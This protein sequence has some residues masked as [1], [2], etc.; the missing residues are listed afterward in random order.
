[1]KFHRRQPDIVFHFGTDVVLLLAC[2]IL[3]GLFTLQYFGTHRVAFLFAPV[4]LV[5]LLCIA[6]VGFYNILHW[7]PSILRALSPY[8]L[9][10]FFKVAGKEGWVSLGG[11]VLCITGIFKIMKVS[12]QFS[13]PFTRISVVIKAGFGLFWQGLRPCLLIWDISL[14]SQFGYAIP[15][16]IH[17][18]V[19][20][21]KSEYHFILCCCR[22]RLC[23]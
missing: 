6:A 15:L 20:H 1:M 14:N 2:I 9:Y 19:H 5:W 17:L 7:N 8:Y 22:L 18:L 3:V 12:L 11:I 21:K 4:I 13:R 10:E 16:Y 23:V